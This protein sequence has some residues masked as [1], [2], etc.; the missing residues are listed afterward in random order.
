MENEEERG[1]WP[2]R[3][4]TWVVIGA[5]VG[6]AAGAIFGWAYAVAGL[7]IGLVAGTTIWLSLR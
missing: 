1:L 3:N 7:F 6:L 5:G 2:P 4:H